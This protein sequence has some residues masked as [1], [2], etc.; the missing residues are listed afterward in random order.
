MVHER[1]TNHSLGSHGQ[2][3][4]RFRCF[5]LFCA[6]TRSY[7]DSIPSIA[8]HVGSTRAWSDSLHSNIAR[9]SATFVC[10]L[11]YGPA[12]HPLPDIIKQKALLARIGLDSSSVAIESGGK[13]VMAL[14]L[15]KLLWPLRLALTALITPIVVAVAPQYGGPLNLGGGSGQSA[16][17]QEK[18]D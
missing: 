15:Q 14:A 6:P 3:L 7:R 17:A 8:R 16:A 5:R 11:A 13:L 2:L 18:R 10:P 4:T 1:T 12:T 9:V